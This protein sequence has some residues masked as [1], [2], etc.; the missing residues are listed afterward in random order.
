M[1]I[2]FNG[3]CGYISNELEM[4]FSMG[5]LGGYS[6]QGYMSFNGLCEDGYF[7]RDVSGRG[8]SNLRHV[9]LPT[10]KLRGCKTCAKDQPVQE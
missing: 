8:I 9:F 4:E 2:C 3:E 6:G 5:F 1:E 10:L 7:R